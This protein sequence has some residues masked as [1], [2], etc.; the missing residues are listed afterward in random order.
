M[1]KKCYQG[2]K[3]GHNV[4]EMHLWEEDKGHQVIPYENIAYQECN[5]E[6]HT[7]IGLNGEHLR[8][9]NN[10]YFSRNPNYSDK[11]TPGLHFHDM[12]VHQ[13]FLVERYG[14]NDMPSTG[15][16]EVFF[17][18]ECEIGGMLYFHKE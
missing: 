7:N 17:D 9:T 18:I 6:D 11:N 14:I 4:W 13:K 5:E 10:W 15:H 8:H 3:L 2:K 16:K 1:Y 12:K